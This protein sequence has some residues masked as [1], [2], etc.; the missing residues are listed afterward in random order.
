MQCTGF[1]DLSQENAEGKL[2]RFRMIDFACRIEST[3]CLN[4]LE[5]HIDDGEELSVNLES[6]VFCYGLMAASAFE[7]GNLDFSEALRTM[8]Q[9]SSSTEYRLRGIDSLGCCS[10]VDVLFNLL[11][12]ILDPTSEVRYLPAENYKIIQSSYSHTFEGVEATMNFV[13]A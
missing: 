4:E 12:S 5:F 10:D 9:V 7:D 6:S 2:S 8:M 3:E 13:I 11:V 1:D